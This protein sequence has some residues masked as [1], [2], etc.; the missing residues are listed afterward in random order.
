MAII[1]K[2][3][4]GDLLTDIDL[5]NPYT[6]AIKNMDSVIKATKHI[7][8][9]FTL[10]GEKNVLAEKDAN[11]T[12]L[13]NDILAGKKIDWSRVD[14]TAIFGDKI[15]E[16]AMRKQEFDAKDSNR[17]DMLTE[18]QRR[19]EIMAANQLRDDESNEVKQALLGQKYNDAK[20]TADQLERER[21]KKLALEES[22]LQYSEGLMGKS[23]DELAEILKNPPTNIPR[24]VV[25]AGVKR[26]REVINPNL[27]PP[28]DGYSVA[29]QAKLDAGIAK[30][31]VPTYGDERELLR[32]TTQ[33]QSPDDVT[34]ELAYTELQ[35]KFP[36]AVYSLSYEDATA[37]ADTALTNDTSRN[38]ID[39]VF[40]DFALTPTALN[41]TLSQKEIKV[42][43]KLI[44]L[45]QTA[46]KDKKTPRGAKIRKAIKD[47]EATAR[48]LESGDTSLDVDVVI[49]NLT[50]AAPGLK[51]ILKP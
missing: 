51:K 20:V 41:L 37:A 9:R 11:T 18:S 17:K 8:D 50:K 4:S 1:F 5:A 28:S 7:T 3:D 39:D 6:N 46:D 48:A 2:D 14:N 12:A 10:Q 23:A 49:K 40:A 36:E 24:R 33:L 29:G 16:I 34:R 22:V 19:T 15:S 27:P 35:Q 13:A 32:L 31:Q 21:Q 26:Y 45:R 47:L 44:K 43:K 25:I 30:A 42:Q 38:W